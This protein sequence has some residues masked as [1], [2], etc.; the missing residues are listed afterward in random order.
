[1]FEIH[2]N[3]AL[4]LVCRFRRKSNV[5]VASVRVELV[6]V[7]AKPGQEGEGDVAMSLTIDV[8]AESSRYIFDQ[9]SYN[10]YVA[11]IWSAPFRNQPG[12][13][14]LPPASPGMIS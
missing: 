6:G 12:A 8:Q 2:L 9:E 13:S 4:I 14:D 1:M 5:L 7:K 3:I 10:R 11:M